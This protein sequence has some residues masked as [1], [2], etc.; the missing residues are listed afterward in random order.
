MVILGMPVKGVGHTVALAVDIDDLA[1]FGKS[2]GACNVH[3]G[4]R[5]AFLCSRRRHHIFPMPDHEI[6][7]GKSVIKTQLV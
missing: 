1:V 2:V 7:F 6:F 4:R 5:S 3:L